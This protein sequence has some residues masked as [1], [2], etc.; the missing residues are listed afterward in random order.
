MKKGLESL[1]TMK[2]LVAAVTELGASAAERFL[3]ENGI[4]RYIDEL[5]TRPKIENAVDIVVIGAGH[6]GLTLAEYLAKVGLSVGVFE[7]REVIGGGLATEQPGYPGFLHNMHSNFH[8]WSDFAPSW[9][10][11]EIPKFGMLYVHPAIPW[12]APLSNKK[13]IL[14]HNNT[15]LTAKNLAQFSKK[16][17]TKY[18]KIK[19]DLDR[20]FHML[21]RAAID[22]VPREEN[23]EGL[24]T[25]EFQSSFSWLRRLS[26]SDQRSLHVQLFVPSRREYIPRRGI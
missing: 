3:L 1:K 2:L 18:G 7:R 8:L 21:M 15:S 19:H 4:N 20:I 16:D 14:I 5:I 17:A 23:P 10:D 9:R 12:S 24:P 22:S 11:L 13:G 25:V 26:H 6:N